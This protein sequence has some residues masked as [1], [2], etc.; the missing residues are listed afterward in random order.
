MTS[1]PTTQDMDSIGSLLSCASE[2]E[3]RE[4]LG[5]LEVMGRETVPRPL[6]DY[7][8]HG[9]WPQQRKFLDLDC[10]EAFY[11]GAA[12]GGKSEALLMAALQYV[13]RPEYKALILRRNTQM[14]E[15]PG[16]LIHRSKEWLSG[17][18]AR[19]NGSRKDW[20]FPSG[21]VITFGHMI[22]DD[23]RYDHQG[24]EYHFVAF[25][26]LTQFSEIGY[27][28]LFSRQRRTTSS[29][30]PIRMRAASNPGGLGHL[31]VKK[32]FI[33]SRGETAVR[34]GRTGILWLNKKRCYVPA[35]IHDN[36]S[37][38]PGEYIERMQHLPPMERARQVSGDWSVSEDALIDASDLRY[39]EERDSGNLLPLGLDGQPF[40]PLVFGHEMYRFVTIDT[41]GTSAE[42]AKEAKGKPASWT[43]AMVW[44]YHA[45]TKMLFLRYVWRARVGFVDLCAGVRQVQRDWKASRLLVENAHLGQA[46]HETLE[47]EMPIER[48]N[49]VTASMKGQSG[50]PGKVERATPLLYKLGKGEVYLP[51]SNATWLADLESEW[52]AWTGQEDET[53]D[54]I[55]GAAYAVVHLDERSGGGKI[56]ASLMIG[57]F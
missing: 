29:Y 30:I 23:K 42:K 17:T 54:Q 25:D 7:C 16:G 56:D 31:W 21:A 4:L 50:R 49:P 44:D 48:I 36:L 41:A 40:G 15:R 22:T 11:G 28:F 37:L 55:D 9:I 34:D 46:V 51:K 57:R 8:P 52:L 3:R 33:D 32:R 20:T 43:V 53:N 19:Y 47:H 27:T 35:S 45:K 13:D 18:D 2:A 1:L 26:E 24:P 14:L 10:E 12:G 39:Y 5:Y 6:R 38:E